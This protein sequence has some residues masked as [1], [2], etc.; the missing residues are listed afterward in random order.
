MVSLFTIHTG[1]ASTPAY[2]SNQSFF[3]KNLL[4]H[5]KLSI[6][7]NTADRHW[8]VQN[9][10]IH[11]M[12]NTSVLFILFISLY[13]VS[14]NKSTK[15]SGII[16]TTTRHTP[17]FTGVVSRGDFN[18]HLSESSEHMVKIICDDNI[19][20]HIETSV[21]NGL[22]TIG[23]KDN[24]SINKTSRLDVYVYGPSISTINQEGSGK[25]RTE[26]KLHSKDLLLV[27]NGSGMMTIADSCAAATIQLN[28]SGN[29]TLSGQAQKQ[30]VSL[31]GS[32]YINTAQ[33][34]SQDAQVDLSGS[35]SATVFATNS[36]D[37]NLSGSGSI[38][39]YGNPPTVTKNISGSGMIKGQ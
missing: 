16:A 39:Y 19:T 32:G 38:F 17:E 15:G 31:K 28:G 35:G 26:N 2:A 23:Y 14:C 36:V 13:F 12:K 5:F 21:Q 1:L 27:M 33:F 8:Y 37:A 29:I 25:M 3:L 10:N 11:L 22:L 24:V 30:T 20:P 18:V 6:Q 7:Q 34:I 4:C 9:L